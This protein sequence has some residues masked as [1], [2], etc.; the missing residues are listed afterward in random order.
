MTTILSIDV[1]IKNLACCYITANSQ[2]D[3]TIDAWEVLDISHYGEINPKC[4]ERDCKMTPKWQVMNK[5]NKY[6]CNYCAK[7]SEKYLVPKKEQTYEYIKNLPLKS[8]QTKFKVPKM[9]KRDILA[10]YYQHTIEMNYLHQIPNHEE[11]KISLQTINKNFVKKIQGFMC[12]C[13]NPDIVLITNQTGARAIRMKAIQNGISMFFQ[14][15]DTKHVL[16]VTPNNKLKGYLPPGI[17]TDAQI[18]KQ[19]YFAA[20]IE[21]M[22][23]RY[24]ERE[25]FE[26]HPKKDDLA[27]CY[28]Q[29]LWFLKYKFDEYIET[30]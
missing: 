18:K 3:Y 25:E 7:Q 6:F 30:S 8:L 26:N 21:L 1:G 13:G 28:L 2:T 20:R 24:E 11:S 22:D 5:I 9:L 15:L 14:I 17:Y 27:S 10:Q 19:S 23:N 29:A 4:W 12:S 16:F